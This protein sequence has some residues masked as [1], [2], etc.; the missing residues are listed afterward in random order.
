MSVIVMIDEVEDMTEGLDKEW[1]YE[2]GVKK[3]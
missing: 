1:S 3:I 2:S